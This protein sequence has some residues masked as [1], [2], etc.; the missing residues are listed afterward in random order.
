MLATSFPLPT[1]AAPDRPVPDRLV[2]VATNDRLAWNGVAALPDGRLFVD[3]PR[4]DPAVPNP[5]LAELRPDG[6]AVPFPGGTWNEWQPGAD[7]AHAFVSVNAVHLGPDGRLWVVDNAASGFI[8]KPPVPGGQKIV[9]IDPRTGAIVRVYRFGA[10]V[11]RPRSAIDDIRF[12]GRHAYV[13]DAGAPGLLVLDLGTG[14]VR[15]LLDGD[16]STSAMRPAIVDGHILRGADGNPARINADQL[17]V[18]PDG[19]SLYYQPLPG[20]LYR[21]ATRL[22]DDPTVRPASLAGSVE[23]W[24]DTP[25]LGGTAIDAA[26]NLYLNDLGTDS[27]LKLGPDRHLT[28][29][30][31]DARL[32]WADAPII[33]TRGNLLVPV[34][35]L[36]RSAAFNHGRSEIHWPVVLYRLHLGA[37]PPANQ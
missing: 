20:P 32:H 37:R 22:L 21:I 25:S 29:V 10:D 8:G 6:T 15:R 7:P 28:L 35:Q 24:Y 9:V 26:G 2:K 27:I 23:F 5:S 17:E 31:H 3:F 36:D 13:T 12:N 18:T 11:L 1:V 30:I 33:D 19:T 34:P 4:I 16:A 14:G